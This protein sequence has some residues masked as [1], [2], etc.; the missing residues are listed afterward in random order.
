M[1]LTVTGKYKIVCGQL[2]HK[3]RTLRET[4]AQLDSCNET[5][6]SLKEE[7]RRLV[8]ALDNTLGE[9]GFAIHSDPTSIAGHL[10][11]DSK[12]R[13]SKSSILACDIAELQFLAEQREDQLRIS[14]FA[15]EK[16]ECCVEEL[17]MS[18]S[19]YKRLILDLKSTMK[20]ERN[21]I[22]SEELPPAGR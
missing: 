12:G 22:R 3:D 20:H 14:E 1:T 18:Q 15:R 2:K 13:I 10:N 5:L 17:K 8:D 21:Q 4:E 16:L 19:M 6:I 7:K 9:L 11:H